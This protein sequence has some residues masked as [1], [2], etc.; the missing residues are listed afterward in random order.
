MQASLY[1]DMRFRSD[2]MS[3]DCLYLNVW[4]PATAAPGARLP[5]L[6]YFYGGGFA[7]GSADEY[8]YDGAAMARRGMVV[9]TANYR[10]GA[11]GFLAHPALTA[12]S[13]DHASGNY[14]LLDQV[15]ALA[16]VHRNVA[17]FGGDPDR[18]T[19]GG[20]S[21]GAFSVADLM[22]SARS[23]GLFAAAIGESGGV[24]RADQSQTLA[25]AERAGVRFAAAAG[26][27]TL[28]DLRRLSADDVLRPTRRPV[29]PPYWSAGIIDGLFLTE[30]PAVTF[31]AGRQAHVPLLVGR[32]DAEMGYRPVIRHGRPTVAAYVA[33]VRRLYGDQADRV[34]A[35]YPPGDTD[36]SARDA[37][38]ALGADRTI[39]TP[40]WRW[41]DLSE[42]TGGCPVYAFS[43]DH[44]RPPVRPGDVP[45]KPAADADP[46][47]ER[48]D[49]SMRTPGAGHSVDIEY[50]LGNLATNRRYD[51]TATDQQASAAVGAYFAAFVR[52]GDPNVASLPAWPAVSVGAGPVMHLDVTPHVEPETGQARHRM[53]DGL[54]A[55]RPVASG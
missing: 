2:G 27:A 46:S 20:E 50:V 32:T 4:T 8:R 17:A 45:D 39:G 34:L 11:F 47:G 31:A 38:A 24:V 48:E 37:A 42:R 40:T 6:V 14:G 30:P 53:L 22:A 52:T 23:R 10:L 41:T 33:D 54:P 26:A 51:W 12:E 16:W 9:V 44:P 7:A 15:A 3:E 43:F 18:V 49:P 1:G 19:I 35:L 55:T 5:V 21:A 36:A 13:P 28:A 29:Q 25:D